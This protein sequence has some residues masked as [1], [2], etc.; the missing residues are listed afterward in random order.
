MP[1][2]VCNNG[3]GRQREQGRNRREVARKEETHS[4]GDVTEYTL[5][6]RIEYL[7]LR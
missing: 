6:E 1:K 3:G 2:A 7:L 4:Q 5:E